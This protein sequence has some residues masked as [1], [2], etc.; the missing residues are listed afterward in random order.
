[1]ITY[2]RKILYVEFALQSNKGIFCW[3]IELSNELENTKR[4]NLWKYT[5]D[6]GSHEYFM[7]VILK[8]QNHDFKKYFHGSMFVY[9]ADRLLYI[10]PIKFASHCLFCSAIMMRLRVMSRLGF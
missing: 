5:L 6:L 9:N 2:K 1:M 8:K 7:L 4:F 3:V 10:Y